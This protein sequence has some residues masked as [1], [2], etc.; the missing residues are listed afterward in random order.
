M[1]LSLIG[2]LVQLA[3]REK[4]GMAEADRLHI[5]LRSL[6]EFGFTSHELSILVRGK[7]AESTIKRE[8]RGV[9]VG[10]KSEHN[11]IIEALRDFVDQGNNLGDLGEYKKAKAALGGKASFSDCTRLASNL[12]A[13]GADLGELVDLSREIAEHHLTAKAIRDNI[14]FNQ[15]LHDKGLTVQ[16]QHKIVDTADKY[17]GAE[18]VLDHMVFVGGSVQLTKQYSVLKD[19]LKTL[20]AEVNESRAI[21]AGYDAEAM[22][23][24]SYVDIVRMLVDD[25]LYDIESLRNLHEVARKFG[26][27][28]A[29]LAALKA[30]ADLNAIKGELS[31]KRDE[32]RDVNVQR[33][34]A[35]AELARLR[36]FIDEANGKISE[37]RERHA[38]S[39]MLQ[40]ASD[41][42]TNPN[43]VRSSSED[44]K[45]LSIAFLGGLTENVER[46]QS[47][48]REFDD[49]VKT[50]MKPA[51]G[52]L[53]RMRR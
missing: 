36:G 34:A 53:E 40:L 10:D 52:R 43:G 26:D 4:L 2:E 50:N 44:L 28:L 7:P 19:Y 16:L 41:L 45:C 47:D 39:R 11:E 33:K 37:I 51:L 5:L 23:V 20:D 46:Y 22:K 13:V 3:G 17:G 30:Y 6:R 32:L 24:K 38:R 42:F 18:K 8:T 31:A 1:A 9:K 21:K 25:Y 49:F 15:M 14:S 48:S 12:V 29:V 35:D 27:H